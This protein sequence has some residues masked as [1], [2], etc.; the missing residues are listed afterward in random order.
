MRLLAKSSAQGFPGTQTIQ[1][2]DTVGRLVETWERDTMGWR[3][4]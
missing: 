2:S 4:I 1:I 3:K